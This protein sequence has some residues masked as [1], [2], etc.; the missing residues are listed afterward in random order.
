MANSRKSSAAQVVE[1]HATNL[2]QYQ[3]ERPI[4]LQE[5][6]RIWRHQ[7]LEGVELFRVRPKRIRQLSA[8]V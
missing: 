4:A 8:L 6:A 3:G 1:G 7:T 5:S 2:L